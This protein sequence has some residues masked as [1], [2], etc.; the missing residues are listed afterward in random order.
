MAAC[1]SLSVAVFELGGVPL[2]SNAARAAATTIQ[3]AWRAAP[4]AEWLQ[5]QRLYQRA[6]YG[7]HDTVTDP[8]Y[9]AAM[10]DEADATFAGDDM[11][12]VDAW[13]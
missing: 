7:Y 3:R 9:A 4:R 10:A 8:D 12:W 11:L 5:H 2:A 13:R 1:P 6:S